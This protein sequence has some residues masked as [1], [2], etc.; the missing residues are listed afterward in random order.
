M[1]GLGKALPLDP[2]LTALDTALN[3]D[4][5]SLA[6]NS[7]IEV[8]R[9][10]GKTAKVKQYGNDMI[11]KDNELKWE[12]TITDGGEDFGKWYTDFSGIY[13]SA[14]LKIILN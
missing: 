9:G 6:P 1:R 11:F 13:P 5:Q 14:V 12:K 8:D 4:G 10:D 2:S 3:I 7:L